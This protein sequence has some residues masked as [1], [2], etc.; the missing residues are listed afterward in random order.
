MARAHAGRGTNRSLGRCPRPWVEPRMRGQHSCH[1]RP[2][3][4]ANPGASRGWLEGTTASTRESARPTRA[5][6]SDGRIELARPW[7]KRD[8]EREKRERMHRRCMTARSTSLQARCAEGERALYARRAAR[9]DRARRPNRSE[10]RRAWRRATR[11]PPTTHGKRKNNKW[12]PK[13]GKGSG[14]RCSPYL[15]H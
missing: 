3:R 4:P 9:H 11:D 5:G 10:K 12:S 7:R 13:N 14:G 1:Q 6:T 15:L 8:E 2:A